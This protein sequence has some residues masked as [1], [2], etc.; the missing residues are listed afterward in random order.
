[1]TDRYRSILVGIN[2]EDVSTTGE[3]RP[4]LD[5]GAAFARGLDL[6]KAHGSKLALLHVF[7]VD[8]LARSYIEKVGTGQGTYLGE[9]QAALAKL[10]ELAK[11]EGVTVT[12]EHAYGKPWEVISAQVAAKGHDLVVVGARRPAGALS[13]Y[14]LR[15]VL[16]GNTAS[17]LVHKCPCPVWVI[18]P[19]SVR[20]YACVLVATD[21]S[22]IGQ[23]ALVHGVRMAEFQQAELHVVHAID[24]WFLGRMPR[25]GPAGSTVES[26]L[27][28]KLA[29]ARDTLA[30]QIATA[31]AGVRLP[32]APK[33]HVEVRPPEDLILRVA[34]AEG[35]DLVVLGTVGRAGVSGFLLGNTAERL[36]PEL[37]C[38]LLVV[39]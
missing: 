13:V 2:L 24:S 28:R 1:M 18:R 34:R 35:A 22:E 32:A 30:K 5:S 37:Q 6:A 9:M 17:R 20:P 29:E 3:E 4:T 31:T 12:A 38:A 19:Q 10:R 33:L 21:L 25:L 39:K 14:A 8:P 11:S 15:H 16:L 36:L 23:R 7:D 26:E 27:A